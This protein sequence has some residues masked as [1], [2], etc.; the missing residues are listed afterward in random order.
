MVETHSLFLQSVL[1]KRINC[2]VGFGENAQ[3]LAVRGSK[4]DRWLGADNE[5]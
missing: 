5:Y 3:T 2:F 4:Q 1:I